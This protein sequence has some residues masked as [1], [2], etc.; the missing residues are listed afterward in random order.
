MPSKD[1]LS[2]VDPRHDHQMVLEAGAISSIVSVFA[3]IFPFSSNTRRTKPVALNPASHVVNPIHQ[4]DPG[5][6]T[7]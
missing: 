5:H 7:G 1:S 3:S 4:A 2:G 6:C